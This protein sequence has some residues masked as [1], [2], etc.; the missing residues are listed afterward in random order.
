[1][2]AGL[3][4]PVAAP[5]PDILVSS[6]AR[7]IVLHDDGSYYLQSRPGASKFVLEAWENRLAA[8]KH[9]PMRTGEP[10]SCK[11]AFCRIGRGGV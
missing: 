6:E 1:M 8:G 5:P 11:A 4:S 10:A 2:L 7:Q 9:V 3:L